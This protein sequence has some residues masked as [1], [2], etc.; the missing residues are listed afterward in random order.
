MLL[1]MQSS[2]EIIEENDMLKE[3]R[4]EIGGESQSPPSFIAS[5]LIHVWNESV[6]SKDEKNGGERLADEL[7]E[8]KLHENTT[9]T[10]G[11]KK[12]MLSSRCSVDSCSSS[13]DEHS[14]L[15]GLSLNS[16]EA[17]NHII[18]CF[19]FATSKHNNDH[20]RG[21]GVI[22]SDED[23]KVL[24]T[25]SA[26]EKKRNLTVKTKKRESLVSFDQ[27][28][29]S[30]STESHTPWKDMRKQFSQSLHQVLNRQN[31]NSGQNRPS[32]LEIS[33]TNNSATPPYLPEATNMFDESMSAPVTP[34][35]FQS[36]TPGILSFGKA[37][38][39]GFGH[40]GTGR[41]T[42][43]CSSNG[44]A[45]SKLCQDNLFFIFTFWEVV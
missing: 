32:T 41:A 13:D 35:Y 24:R 29:N 40:S 7:G 27:S 26:N 2:I 4:E 33:N 10:L 22:E 12:S 23:K 20:L 36:S 1:A 11:M 15:H 42:E 6:V 37:K 14:F 28:H 30:T 9:E 17:L 39:G 3:R 8:C 31:S 44:S 16:H 21:E 19:P 5:S 45:L 38:K 18:R 43:K 25:Q 34:Q